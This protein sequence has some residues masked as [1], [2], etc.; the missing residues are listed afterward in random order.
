MSEPW[1]DD[2]R[3]ELDV[4]KALAEIDGRRYAAATLMTES[5]KYF[6]RLEDEKAKLLRNLSK[7]FTTEG[8]ELRKAFD[9]KYFPDGLM[10]PRKRG[11]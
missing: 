6:E 11:A 9:K 3:E 8:D 1:P 4:C 10:N 2:V 5:S 7:Q